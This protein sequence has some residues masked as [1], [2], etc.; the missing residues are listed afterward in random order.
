MSR[1]LPHVAVVALGLLWVASMPMAFTGLD[2]GELGAAAAELGVAHPP[3]YAAFVMTRHAL[4]GLPLADLAARIALGSALMAALG[5]AAGVAVCL[6]LGASRLA[7]ALVPLALCASPVFGLHATTI[8]VYADLPVWMAAAVA[9]SARAASDPR[10]LLGLAALVGLALGH[11][12]ELRVFGVALGLAAL[13]P[14]RRSPRVWLG[15]TLAALSGALVVLYLPL[16]ATRGPMRNWG[17]PSTPEALWALLSGARIRAAYHAEFLRFDALAAEAFVAQHAV[18]LLLA[19]ALSL[20]ALGAVW[21]R[22]RRGDTARLKATPALGVVAGL[23]T[24][25]ALDFV[26]A[27]CL[28]PMGVR[29]AQ[30]G[31]PLAF[32]CALLTGVAARRGW[33]SRAL[34]VALCAAAWPAAA[35]LLEGASDRVAAAV[36]DRTLDDVPVSGVVFAA[37]DD[38][39]AGAAFAQTAEAARP[40]VAV[41][42][43]QH[44]WDASSLDPTLRRLPALAPGWRVGDGLSALARVVDAERPWRWEGARG[45]DAEAL[46]R[47]VLDAAPLASP[48]PPAQVP[49][50]VVRSTAERLTRMG[51]VGTGAALRRWLVHQASD[52]GLLGRSTDP[53]DETAA[54]LEVA[55]AA[56]LPGDAAPCV[57]LGATLF[58]WGQGVAARHALERARALNA[59]DEG[60]YLNLARVSL[61]AADAD[62][63]LTWLAV[64]FDDALWRTRASAAQALALR[65][66]AHAQRADWREARADLEAA[67]ALVPDQPDALTGL[68]A[69]GDSGR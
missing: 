44:A 40:D 43:R 17:D 1:F 28:N 29:D 14:W 9:M 57:N 36:L 25:G 20:S 15:A 51:A 47:P 63:A 12:A 2:A 7:A 26:Y 16:A 37:S 58:E 52:L 67:R 11:H 61:N 30:N 22:R 19:A 35:T 4:T 32:A 10:G 45:L 64:G 69:L 8:E 23:V 60:V 54:A 3:G 5:A 53:R 50:E 24:L 66:L 34:L 13:W 65:G 41:V 62:D 21:A 59:N 49:L 39:A 27:T 46:P 48:Q 38:L 6:R 18:S 42:V 33:G 55:C 31:V 56:G 68:G